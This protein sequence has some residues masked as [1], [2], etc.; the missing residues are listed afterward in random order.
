MTA[1]SSKTSE[2]NKSQASAAGDNQT[3]KDE[4]KTLEEVQAD[5]ANAQAIA[6]YKQAVYEAESTRDK[7]KA[8]NKDLKEAAGKARNAQKAATAKVPNLEAKLKDSNKAEKDLTKAV[9]VAK[10]ALAAAEEAFTNIGETVK[11]VEKDLKTAK[12]DLGAAN[13]AL[14]TA[15]TGEAKATL[16]AD[17]GDK[18][19]DATCALTIIAARDDRDKALAEAEALVSPCQRKH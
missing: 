16:D 2:A 8:D 1:T 7:A 5:L 10:K 6:T 11:T 18:I 3:G 19:A 15:E 12:D 14:E 13:S 17:V 4:E 9:E